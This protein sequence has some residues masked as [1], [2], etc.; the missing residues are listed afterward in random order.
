MGVKRN[1]SGQYNGT[2]KVSL[3]TSEGGLNADGCNAGTFSSHRTSRDIIFK[4]SDVEYQR[5]NV[6]DDEL[7]LSKIVDM[8]T[9]SLKTN[10]F[11][12]SAV[13]TKISFYENAF[14]NMKHKNSTADATCNGL[15]ILDNLYTMDVYP[16]ITKLPYNTSKK[17]VLIQMEQRMEIIKTLI[18][19]ILQYQTAYKDQTMLLWEMVSI[20]FIAVIKQQQ[21]MVI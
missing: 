16:S 18:V 20:D 11:N 8:K 21:M 10:S 1:G 15:K 7:Q 13:N 5:F 17:H 19:Q 14:E 2:L 3:L 9:S 12:T 4:H 6:T